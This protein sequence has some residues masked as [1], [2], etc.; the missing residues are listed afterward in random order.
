MYCTVA[1]KYVVDR[2]LRSDFLD[3]SD[4]HCKI[5]ASPNNPKNF[6]NEMS[7]NPWKKL[8]KFNSAKK[9]PH[10]YDN[11]IKYLQKKVVISA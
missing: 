3:N 8:L 1:K 11:S 9:N 5:K 10:F 4:Q 6:M 7:I 2:S